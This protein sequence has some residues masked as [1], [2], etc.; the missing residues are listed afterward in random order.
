MTAFW[1]PFADMHA[2]ERD[3]ELVISRGEGSYIWDTEGNKYFDAGAALWYCNVGH[4]RKEIGEAMAKQTAE[5]AS[6]TAFGDLANPQSSSSPRKL[7]RLLQFLI[8]K[9]FSHPEEVTA[10]TPQ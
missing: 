4:G 5:L 1:H 9:C 2:V 7:L 10:S 8:R 3:G 6:Y